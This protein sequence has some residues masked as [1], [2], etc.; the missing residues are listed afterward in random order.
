MFYAEA[1][2]SKKGPLAKVWLAAHW[3]RKLSKTQFLQ[4]NIPSSV[5][6]MMSGDQPPLALRLSGQLLLGVVRIYY[7]KA[8]YLLEDCDDALFKIK[9]AFRPGVVDMPNENAT[10]NFNAITLP[11]SITEFDM[12]LP[13]P[14]LPLPGVT[15][16][17][18]GPDVERAVGLYVSRAQDI[19]LDDSFDIGA[20]SIAFD[21][22]DLL[23][24][25]MLEGD[26]DDGGFRL[27]FTEDIPATPFPT[28]TA[29][30]EEDTD[31]PRPVE[32][33]MEVEVGR[34]AHVDLSFAPESPGALLRPD[35]SGLFPEDDTGAGLVQSSVFSPKSPEVP[36][37]FTQALN[38]E[39]EDS[40]L[41]GPGHL[42]ATPMT[43]QVG[44]GTDT[45]LPETP[46]ALL[47]EQP[48][49]TIPRQPR[50][51]KLVVD[52][53]TEISSQLIKAQIED[54]SDITV[55]D[56]CL[57]SKAPRLDGATAFPRTLRLFHYTVPLG[58]PKALSHLFV[59]TLPI[60]RPAVTAEP[61]V[62]D[63][64]IRADDT[65]SLAAGES[66][67]LE[68]AAGEDLLPPFDAVDDD[69]GF[70]LDFGDFPLEEPPTDLPE[71][72]T[73]PPLDPAIPDEGRRLTKLFGDAELAEIQA[74]DHGAETG[75]GEIIPTATIQ[76]TGDTTTVGFSK[77]TLRAI[78]LIQHETRKTAAA[79]EDGHMAS[80]QMPREADGHQLAFEPIVENVRRQD[81]V[82]L[83]FELLVLKTK[84]FIDVKQTRPF[85]DISIIPRDKLLQV[86]NI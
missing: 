14:E 2:L 40:I 55:N 83:F 79:A 34:D 74:A 9:L 60:A 25:A 73:V 82:K 3:E 21:D 86:E 28:T 47:F 5:G 65:G 70:R 41:G 16:G 78:Q 4:T 24:N 29:Y 76:A 44:V 51:R 72:S 48:T 50:K 39:E 42:I 53:T 20:R 33:S 63:D 30:G 37:N 31:G 59:R 11:D 32:D 15:G 58:V 66:S 84:D 80:T 27:D 17:G 69:Q 13:D 67:L 18:V 19:T 36:L 6:A 71:D 7:R 8:K 85:G 26:E 22:G 52:R 35:Q 57:P 38:L 75:D 54:T 1:I 56:V 23:G 43:P 45:A 46:Q 10:A 61:D 77:S 64:V 49:L 81:T 68:P 12:M 62:T